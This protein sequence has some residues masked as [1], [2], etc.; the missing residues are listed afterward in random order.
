MNLEQHY[1]QFILQFQGNYGTETLKEILKEFIDIDYHIN[2]IEE[3]IFFVV[4][5]KMK[6][7]KKFE[8][9]KKK[10]IEILGRIDGLYLT[11][12]YDSQT[13][14][15]LQK[16]SSSIY[17]LERN[18]RN[19]IE[20]KMLRKVGTSW[21]SKYLT[22]NDSTFD[23]KTGRKDEVFKYLANPLDDYNFKNL[24]GF[25]K[26]NIGKNKNEIFERLEI[27][28]NKIEEFRNKKSNIDFSEI[29]DK[30]IEEIDELKKSIYSNSNLFSEDIYSHIKPDLVQEWNRIYDFRNY[31]A[32]NI[33][34][35]T[36]TEYSEYERLRLRINKKIL[37]ELTI[38]S[39]LGM[40]SIKDFDN[41]TGI[42]FTVSKYENEVVHCEIKIKFKVK[43][44]NLYV[45]KL[46]ADY[47]D[48]HKFYS[49]L[50]QY[51]REFI[52]S[53]NTIYSK[54]PYLFN[55]LFDN[56]EMSS[57]LEEI[58]EDIL[59][60]IIENLKQNGFNVKTENE[61]GEGLVFINE[62]HHNYLKAILSPGNN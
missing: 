53:I 52:E 60:Q 15:H 9:N 5:D 58:T 2:L 61:S 47:T 23:R 14:K 13:A 38:D 18:F 33:F 32:H 39:L 1:T 62:D 25:V 17:E 26:E 7:P 22:P 30:I 49:T 24:G 28:D 8:K 44:K 3:H 34:L 57:W 16:I 27:L 4:Y 59:Q 55:A 56:T 35:M 51:K 40:E 12:L 31:W 46:E 48:I 21:S 6:I 41:G 54:N 20:I 42:R 36:E 29:T 11:I 50:F 43:E 45:S 19:L 10:I 37:V